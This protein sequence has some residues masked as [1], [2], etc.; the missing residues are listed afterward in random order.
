MKVCIHLQ[1]AAGT[2]GGAEALATNLAVMLRARHRVE[3]VHHRPWMSSARLCAFAGVDLSDVSLRFIERRGNYFL[4][5][6]SNPIDM[7]RQP[8]Q[9]G[10]DLVGEADAVISLTH[11]LPP[12]NPTP[13][14][15]LFLLF[16]FT[17]P[18]A[19]WPLVQV[20][21]DAASLKV[22]LGRQFYEQHYRALW[23]GYQT[24]LAISDFAGHWARER[25]GIACDVLSP[26]VDCSVG[27]VPKRT[28]VITVARFAVAGVSKR[29]HEMATAFASA[30]AL[31]AWRLVCVGSALTRE[32]VAYAHDVAIVDPRID[33]R[34]NLS[35]SAVLDSL[36]SARV[37]WHAAGL[38][39]DETTQPELLEHF[40]MATVEAMANG[41]VPVVI[42]RGGQR[43]IVEHGHSGF[44]CESLEEMTH[45]T[46]QLAGDEVLWQRMSGAARA[47]AA[48]FSGEAFGRR[49]RA[50]APFL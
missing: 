13:H 32:E 10:R 36:S 1:P 23:R 26:L 35:R 37:F 9:W 11:D 3:I 44:L 22:R 28:E 20:R 18:L 38:G 15:V 39:T 42:G 6:S 33:V 19:D 34:A 24:R 50:L 40:G 21:D 49:L 12:F 7:Y 45:R 16:P 29:Q 5:G 41:C 46:A 43:E 2:L 27:S 25:W 8:R 14:G 4:T 31:A 48:R 30:P 47:G 17:N